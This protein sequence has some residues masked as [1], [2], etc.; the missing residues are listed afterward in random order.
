MVRLIHIFLHY[1]GFWVGHQG[2]LS[3][4]I[5]LLRVPAR[6]DSEDDTVQPSI[7]EFDAREQAGGVNDHLSSRIEIEDS[8]DDELVQEVVY[9]MKDVVNGISAFNTLGSEQRL[10]P[11]PTDLISNRNADENEI[12]VIDESQGVNS[13]LDKSHESLSG[14]YIKSA[15]R[16]IRSIPLKNCSAYK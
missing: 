7:E 16:N 3:S 12:D 1:I 4:Q 11:I 14:Q 15:R 5:L 2:L 13:T 8:S 9:E 6:S 10:L